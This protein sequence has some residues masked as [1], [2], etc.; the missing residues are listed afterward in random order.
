MNIYKNL[1]KYILMIRC[2]IYNNTIV[3]LYIYMSVQ[4]FI[5][6]NN[7]EMLWEVI[8]DEGLFKYLSR[9]DQ[10][11]IYQ[12]FLNN[13]QG[14]FDI[15]KIKNETLVDINKKYIV[16]ILTYIKNNYINQ[17]NKI[18]IYKEPIKESI[19]YEEIQ[20]DKRFNFERDL[21]KR[22]EEFEDSMNIKAPPQPEFADKERDI[23]I[24]EMENILKE[25]QEKRN[26]EIEQINKNYNNNQV[27]NWLKP[28]ETSLKS[29]KFTSE[30][31]GNNNNN[32]IGNNDTRFKF[33]NKQD[34]LFNNNNNN[35]IYINKKNVTFNDVDEIQTII[36]NDD[37]E[38][39][40]IFLKLKKLSNDRANPQFEN[41]IN[42]NKDIYNKG[43]INDKNIINEL[44][45]E[46]KNINI[47]MDKILNLLYNNKH[48]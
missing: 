33:L 31:N 43:I 5:K 47:K 8:S 32:I 36:D 4:Q 9:D 18:T 6:K 28:Q 15:E 44:K 46:L 42:N 3:I 14:F 35:N 41:S 24:K 34:S 48:T 25:M 2:R 7:I 12:L 13:I 30:N 45:N 10:V 27:D 26:Y 29:E 20:N 16:L 17:P 21:N 22:Q 19:T 40:S 11:K 39:D 38:Q 1:E 37:D 23:P